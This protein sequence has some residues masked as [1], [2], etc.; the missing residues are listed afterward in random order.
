MHRVTCTDCGVKNEKLAFLSGNTKYTLRFAMQIGGLC[1]AMTITD[2]A[3]RMH[4]DWHTVKELDKLYMNEQLRRAP[5]P[6]PAVVG[7]D[8][9]SM[10]KGHTYRIVS[11]QVGR[12]GLAAWTVP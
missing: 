11:S 4:L 3:R 9:I 5:A 12:S 7:I 8:E 1:R 10:G 2:V 6:Q